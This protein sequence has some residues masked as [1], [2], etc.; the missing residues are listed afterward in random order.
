MSIIHRTYLY[1]GGHS[2]L[3]LLFFKHQFS[4]DRFARVA[5]LCMFW[6]LLPV[7]MGIWTLVV[8]QGGII[9]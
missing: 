9:W 6:Y 3:Y 2:N 4:S 5:E 7:C 8:A 1:H